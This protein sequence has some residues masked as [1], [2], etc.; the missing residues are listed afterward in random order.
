MVKKY[1]KALHVSFCAQKL[2]C[3][4]IRNVFGKHM[5]P[6]FP[7]I[8]LL[9]GITKQGAQSLTANRYKQSVAVCTTDIACNL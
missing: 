8:S 3:K 4:I 9:L 6:D 5:Y 1:T 7:M 2:A